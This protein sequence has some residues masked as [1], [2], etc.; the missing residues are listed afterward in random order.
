MTRKM[1]TRLARVLLFTVAFVATVVL[2]YYQ[3]RTGPTWPVSVRETL[4]GGA[5][6][7][8]L[9]R[10]HAGAGTALL[11]LEAPPE[12][13]GE[14]LWRRFPTDDPWNHALLQRKGNRLETTL[15][16]Q[17]PAG[18]VEYSL[19]L[20]SGGETRVIPPGGTI[21]LRFR[22][23]VPAWVLVPHI[24][25]MFFALLVGLRAG[26]GAVLGE[27]RPGRFVP[28]VLVLLIPGGLLFGPLVQK[29]AFGSFWTGWPLGEDW[30]D[31]KTLASVLLWVVAAFLVRHGGRT[32][33]LAVLAATVVMLAVYLVPHSANG[34]QLDWEEIERRQAGTG[35]LDRPAEALPTN[36]SVPSWP[37]AGSGLG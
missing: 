6:H 3:R 26:L 14:V 37:D 35:A 13:T 9:P 24:L 30:T 22:G 11:S 28:W 32:E 4:S 12:A 23:D 2:A 10:S 1:D 15:P 20:H 21:V 25:L 18:K 31:T 7:G 29:M 19:R 36:G 5:V 34:S 33:R 27:S 17:P 8:R 16:H